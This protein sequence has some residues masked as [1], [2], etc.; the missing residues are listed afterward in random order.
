MPYLDQLTEDGGDPVDVDTR[1]KSLLTADELSTL[2]PVM[3]MG[4][5]WID[6][7]KMMCHTV[8]LFC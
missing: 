5:A 2:R 3:L 4:A 1:V 6:K 7:D 8:P